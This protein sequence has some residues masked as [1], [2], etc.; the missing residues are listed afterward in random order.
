MT[1]SQIG[2]GATR[3]VLVTPASQV[4]VERQV[5]VKTDFYPLD[6]VT[7]IAGRAG[8]GKSTLALADAAAATQGTLPGDYVGQRLTVALTATEDTKSMQTARLRA[9]GADL[10]RV[11]F[12]DIGNQVAGETL[13]SVPH[14]PEDLDQ[15]R[16]T[17]I[18]H[19]VLLW[20]IDPLTALVSGDTNRRDDVRAALD[21][22]H[23]LARELHIAVVGILHFG[24]GAGYASDKISG[25]HAFR[26]VARSVLLVAHDDDSGE[27]VVTLDKS[28]YSQAAGKSWAFQLTDTPVTGSDGEI[29]HVPRVTGMVETDTDVNT[30]INREMVSAE[31]DDRTEGER[32]L[33]D[34]LTGSGGSAPAKQII[35]AAVSDGFSKATIQRAGKKLCEKSSGGFQQPWAWTLREGSHQGSQGSHSLESENDE[36]NAENLGSNPR[37]LCPFHHAELV[38]GTCPECSQIAAEGRAA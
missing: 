27:H 9:A 14:I 6:V 19:G 32:W 1:L 31:D 22:L 2:T 25:S 13:E 7:L 5:F 26:D 3:V 21:P 16:Q 15:I 36:N 34:Y 23:A 33:E 11:L 4:A 8:E 10:D 35:T 30:I 20:I 38:D 18:D 37:A 24:K 29:Q 28:N 17:L 12:L